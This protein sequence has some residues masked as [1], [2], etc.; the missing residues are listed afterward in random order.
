[1]ALSGWWRAIIKNMSQM[2]FTTTANQFITGHKET[3]IFTN[4]DI[5]RGNGLIIT[6]PAGSG[7]KFAVRKIEI[8]AASG[9][10]VDSILFISQ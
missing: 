4:G 9:T 3:T 7:I 5:F 6:W 8:V 2:G 1:M 10:T